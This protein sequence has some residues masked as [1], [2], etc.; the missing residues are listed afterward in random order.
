MTGSLLAESPPAEPAIEE[1]DREH[2]AFQPLNVPEMPV[3]GNRSWCRSGVDRFILATLESEGLKPI[4]EA[5]RGTLIRRVSFDLI[6][7]PPTPEDVQRFLADDRPDAYERLVDELLADPAYGERW[8]QH[9]LDL[10]RFAET[11]G[12]EHDKVRHEAWRYRDWVIDA[13]NCDLPY[14]QFL[15]HQIAGDEVAPQDP[16]AQIATGFLL[17]GP[18]MPDINSQVERR[19]VF[20]NGLTATIGEVCLGLQMGCAECHHHKSDPISTHDFYRLRAYFDSLDLFQDHP[21]QTEESDTEPATYRIAR[22]KNGSG[23]SHVWIRGDY[24]RPGPRISAAYPRVLRSGV[25]NAEHQASSRADLVRSLTESNNALPAR[26]IVNRLWQH[27]FRSGLCPTASDFGLMGQFPT[28]PELLD[29]LAAELIRNDW[30]LKALHRLL[31]TSAVYRTA[32]RPRT[33]HDDAWVDLLEDD[34]ENEFLGR[35]HRRRLDGEAIRDTLLQVSGQLNQQLAGPGVRPPLP[36]EVVQ[37]LLKNQWPVTENTADHNRRS[38][39]LFARRNLRFPLFEVFDKP[40][41]NQSCARRSETV[42]AP[43]ALHLLN[44]E[45]VLASANRLAQTIESSVVG[46]DARIEACYQRVLARA[47]QPQEFIDTRVF[48]THSD[49]G[50]FDL[51]LALMNLN[52]FLYID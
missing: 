6:G 47:P 25:D 52:E 19:H 14:H 37:T 40:D 32:S 17:S 21:L 45:F 22:N 28:H 20:L 23:A 5:D 3:V 26:V 50:L 29:W 36:P 13:L 35:M 9:W 16:A 33:P 10:A 27:H 51:C 1:I 11:D 48:L 15:A 24:R 39:Y 30:S 12:F 43:Q 2:W 38:I 44:S 4:Q 46:S 31:V 49:N 34:P 7:L 42:I 18:D 8:G 41:S